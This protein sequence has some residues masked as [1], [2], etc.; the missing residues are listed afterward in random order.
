MQFVHGLV[1]Y[2]GCALGKGSAIIFILPMNYLFLRQQ[3][4]SS[5]QQLSKAPQIDLIV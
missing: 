4:K 5:I 1:I 3:I 2:F